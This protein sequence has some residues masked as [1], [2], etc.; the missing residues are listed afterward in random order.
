[1]RPEIPKCGVGVLTVISRD[2]VPCV[3]SLEKKFIAPNPGAKGGINLHRVTRLCSS[4]Y[5]LIL[6]KNFYIF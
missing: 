6:Q 4:L 3:P 5:K 2:L 1:V